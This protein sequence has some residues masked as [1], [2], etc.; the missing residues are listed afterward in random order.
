MNNKPVN[1]SVQYY[2]HND[3]FFFYPTIVIALMA[4]LIQS[5]TG[6]EFSQLGGMFLITLFSNIVLVNVKVKGVWSFM[7][8]MF[9]SILAYA[10]YETGIWQAMLP[11]FADLDLALSTDFYTLIGA[12]L[13]LVW[14]LVFFAYDRRTYVKVGN[15]QV[16]FLQEVGEHSQYFPL[17]RVSFQ[18]H[19]QNIILSFFG[20][21]SG[22]LS[23]NHEGKTYVMQNIINIDYVLNNIE[24]IR[25]GNRKPPMDT[26]LY[27]VAEKTLY[28]I[29][30]KE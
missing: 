9:L 21:G 27:P 18:K 20:F 28:P 7:L 5:F 2:S 19:K 23:I 8:I 15:G 24:S 3:L 6:K 17:N 30:K 16:S 4:F 14:A 29:D 22:D 12:S 1:N 26:A 11:W 13:I 10:M 25:G